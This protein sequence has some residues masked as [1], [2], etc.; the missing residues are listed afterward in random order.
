MT[1]SFT[2]MEWEKGVLTGVFVGGIVG[3]LAALLFAPAS[4]REF[5]LNLKEQF[6][7]LTEGT[8]EMIEKTEAQ[9]SEAINNAKRSLGVKE[10]QLKHAVKAGMD[11][12][13][14]GMQ[15]S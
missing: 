11:A 15:Q 14:L 8:Q 13:K 2:R 9:T 5:R 3:V 1:T 10:T 7:R 4:G 6:A 12:Y